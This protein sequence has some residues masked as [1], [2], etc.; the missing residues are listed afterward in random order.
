[1]IISKAL[2]QDLNNCISVISP[3][4]LFVL[5]DTSSREYC[6]PLIRKCPALASAKVFSMRSGD[7]FKNL[8]TVVDVWTFLGENG[9][10]RQS[11]L[12]NLGGGVVTDLGGFVANTFKRGIR[13]IN[14]P[15]TLLSMVDAAVGGKTG[16]NF[17]Q[18]KNEIGVINPAEKVL[19]CSEFL[20]TLDKENLLSGYAEMLKHGLLKSQEELHRLAS[21]DINRPDYDLLSDLIGTSVAVKEAIVAVDPTEKGI[22]KALNLGH[23]IGHAFESLSHTQKRPILHGYAVAYGL[24]GE[25]YLSYKCQGF[26][27]DEMIRLCRFISENYGRFEIDCDDYPALYELMAHDK[28]NRHAGEINCTLLSDVGQ[29]V[30]DCIIEKEQIFKALDFYRDTVGI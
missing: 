16:I 13:Y 14:I 15:T 6:L 21:F 12:I 27:Q 11:M 8:D 5:T 19:I 18:L 26:P 30:T 25:L 2:V 29:I 17:R 24:I 10:T 23:T 7:D 4:Q 20:R 1:M 3:E 9:G 22:R 28:K